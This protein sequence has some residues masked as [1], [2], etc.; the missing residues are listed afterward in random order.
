MHASALSVGGVHI[1]LLCTQHFDNRNISLFASQHQRTT[2]FEVNGI[3]MC[4]EGDEILL[5]NI[6]KHIV[7]YLI[8]VF[9]QHETIKK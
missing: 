9:L 3:R 7:K 5:I 2:A 4:T 1:G 6:V 8:R